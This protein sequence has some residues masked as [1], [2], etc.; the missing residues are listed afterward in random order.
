MEQVAVSTMVEPREGLEGRGEF[1]MG[2]P[3]QYQDMYLFK[4]MRINC[5]AYAADEQC[6]RVLKELGTIRGK[7]AK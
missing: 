2:L 6:S 1:Y 7:T 5:A 4:M 3:Y